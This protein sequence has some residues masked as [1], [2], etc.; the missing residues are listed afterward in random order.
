MARDVVKE[1]KRS[2]KAC[3]QRRNTS[4]ICPGLDMFLVFS[5]ISSL[6]HSNMRRRQYD[7]LHQKIT[8]KSNLT[9]FMLHGDTS[10]QNSSCDGKKSPHTGDSPLTRV[11]A[12]GI[13]ILL[14]A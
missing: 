13:L 11:Q 6:D 4:K 7:S 5:G 2:M 9:L 12:T 1:R 14:V 10:S 3:K 8:V